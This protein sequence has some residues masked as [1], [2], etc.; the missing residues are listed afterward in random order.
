M[1]KQSID[2]PEVLEDA[3]LSRVP[4]NELG[5]VYLFS[6]YAKKKKI[7]VEE[8]RPQFPDCIAYQKI[9]GKEKRIRI[10]FEFRSR[11]FKN[12]TG[13]DPKKCDWIV[14]WQHDW[15]DVPK[16]IHVVELR[17]EYGMGFNV[18]IQ[19]VGGEFGKILSEGDKWDWSVP[20]LSN[21]G[22]LLLYYHKS[23]EKC[24]KD[25]F[26]LTSSVYRSAATH[27]KRKAKGKDYYGSIRRVCSLKSPIFFENLKRDRIL[28]TAYF[29]RN[30]MRGRAKATEFWP[31]IYDMII[32][33]NPSLKKVL[34][35]YS[36]ERI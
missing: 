14:C 30:G 21:K 25:I 2:R 11:N 24:I 1:K 32:S 28:R 29:I 23:P 18:W 10:E 19:P 7:K 6:D 16:N 34:A 8:I 20:G 31:D 17:N 36:P 9:G 33:R 27:R 26:R 4:Q 22:D 12:Q 35:K 13:H 3:P 5:V 15:H